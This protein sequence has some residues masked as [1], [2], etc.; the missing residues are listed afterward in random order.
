MNVTEVVS[1]EQGESIREDK[2]TLC[3]D[4][5]QAMR[6]VNAEYQKIDWEDQEFLNRV[7]NCAIKILEAPEAN[8]CL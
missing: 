7:L 4:L 1:S 8:L 3:G 5:R 6:I 2:E